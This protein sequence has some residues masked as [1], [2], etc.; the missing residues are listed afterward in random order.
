[1]NAAEV[2][3]AF[4]RDIGDVCCY[5]PLFTEFPNES[6]GGGVVNGCE[7]HVDVVEIRGLEFPVIVSDLALLYSMDHFWV[8][9][10]AG[11]DDGDFGVGVQD[12]EDATCCYLE[13]RL[14]RMSLGTNAV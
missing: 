13:Q 14:G 11:G 2:E 12:I 7:N 10:R 3:I 6:G 5:F 1:M 4:W 9:A 8:E